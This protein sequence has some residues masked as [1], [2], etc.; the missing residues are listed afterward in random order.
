MSK[1]ARR[2]SISPCS[3]TG[4]ARWR[5]GPR[6]GRTAPSFRPFLVR[7]QLRGRG[8]GRALLQRLARHWRGKDF[9]RVAVTVNVADR[10]TAAFFAR[11][12]F[13]ALAGAEV[14]YDGDRWDRVMLW[15]P[16]ARPAA[17]AKA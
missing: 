12:G 3:A 9:D 4:S 6:R 7:P 15:T 1:A 17:V 8:V 2:R 5:S 16:D 14:R 10:A 11:N 13:A